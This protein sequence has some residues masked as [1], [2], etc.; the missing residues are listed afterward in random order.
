MRFIRPIASSVIGLPENQGI[1]SLVVDLGRGCRVPLHIMYYTLYH[2]DVYSRTE[3]LAIFTPNSG[4]PI[5]SPLRRILRGLSCEL[6]G[7]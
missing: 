2:W 4:Y 5:H 7:W 3:V 6:M 1:L